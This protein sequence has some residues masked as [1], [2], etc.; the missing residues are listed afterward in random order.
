M[1]ITSDKGAAFAFSRQ[2]V[3]PAPRRPYRYGGAV[4]NIEIDDRSG[5][6]P[7]RHDA[8]AVRRAEALAAWSRS[9][10]SST[11]G[12]P[13]LVDV[14]PRPGAT[15]DVLDDARHA[16][17]GASGGS[18]RRRPHRRP[19]RRL[20]A[21]H[22][23][24]R[25]SLRRPRLA[26]R[27]RHR[28]AGLGGGPA[29]PRQPRSSNITPAGHRDCRGSDPGGR[30][31]CAANACPR[32][33]R[34]CIKAKIWRTPRHE[35]ASKPERI[36]LFRPHRRQHRGRCHRAS[37]R[38][39]DRR[40][41]RAPDRHGCQRAGRAGSRPPP[42]RGLHGRPWHRGDH[43]R[44]G[45]ER[46]PLGVVVHSTNPVIA[47]LGSQYAGWTITEERAAS[48]R[49]ARAPL[50]RCRA[51]RSCIPSSATST[52]TRRRLSSSKATRR[53]PRP[54]SGGRQR[55]QRRSQRPDDPVRADAQPR[56]HRA[57]RRPRA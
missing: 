52:A 2:W 27:A 56:R 22:G 46:W 8:G 15:L 45:N 41:R 33:N 50:A 39:L 26:D 14:N 42:G 17:Q 38:C 28:L 40:G 20:G 6:P 1:G 16:F 5:S 13:M 47:C 10:S 51:S 3:A 29:R 30:R 48:S 43:E 9:T 34:C 32:S 31:S 35:Q 4:G 11:G 57:D 18:R 24:R 36:G 21:R 44:S 25:L 19:A 53:R 7:R 37:L 49:S 23:R 54:W 55:L 12:E